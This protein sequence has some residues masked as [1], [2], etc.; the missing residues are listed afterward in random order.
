MLNAMHPIRFTLVLAVR[1]VLRHPRRTAIAVSSV[2]AGIV[3]LMLANGFVEWVFH[4]MRESMIRAHLGHLQIVRRG[5]HDAGHA[6]G[7]AFLLPERGDAW[8]IVN[9]DPDVKIVAPRLSFTGL[10][11]SGQTTVSF[12]GEAV[13]A[14]REA[15]LSSE[16]DIVEGEPLKG[17]DE[18]RALVGEGLARNLGVNVGDS[19]VLLV[20][21][22]SGGVNAVEVKVGGL[23]RTVTKAYD[24]NALRLPIGTARRLLGVKGAHVW[25]ALLSDTARTDLVAQRL[26]KALPRDLEVVRWYELADFYNKTVALFSKQ[27]DVVRIIIA[28]IIVLSITNTMVRSVTER[29]GEI[30]TAMALGAPRR[31]IL[32]SFLAEGATLGVVG[33]AAGVVLGVAL[34]AGISA[35]GIPMP[36]PPGMGHGFLAQI[37]ITPGLAGQ[38]FA[39]AVL[40]TLAASV[41][42]AWKASRLAIVDALRHNR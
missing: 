10:A 21:K 38:A 31:R 41:Y 18:A 39:L 8:D 4:D 20:T 24:D 37:R 25:V 22:P 11:S 6:D 14:E 36:P 42:P 32:G 19:L 33:G 30:G 17:D 40:T 7:Q 28:A 9:R 2:A 13:S 16:L 23:F 29:T 5:W 27:I 1:S 3:A 12:L 34:A 26:E 15:K 35:A